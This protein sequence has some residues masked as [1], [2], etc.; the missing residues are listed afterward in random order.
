MSEVFIFWTTE[1]LLPSE[2]IQSFLIKNGHDRA[3]NKN[4]KNGRLTQFQLGRRMLFTVKI[5]RKNW[6]RLE[7]SQ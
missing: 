7:I 5:T 1:V 4:K 3:K 6:G 2:E